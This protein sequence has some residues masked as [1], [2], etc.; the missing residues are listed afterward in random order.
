MLNGAGN[1]TINVQ[2]LWVHIDESGSKSMVKIVSFQLSVRGQYSKE[3][4][5]PGD[6]FSDGLSV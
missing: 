5:N 4:S 3:P 6:F 2:K 1:S